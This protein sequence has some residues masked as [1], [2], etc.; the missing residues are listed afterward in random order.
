MQNKPHFLHQFGA[1]S[2]WT[3]HD[4]TIKAHEMFTLDFVTTKPNVFVITNSNNEAIKVGINNIPTDNSYEFK[5]E[6][7]STET[8]GRPVGTTK[9]YLLNTGGTEIN[10]IVFAID[11]EFDPEILKNTNVN[12]SVE[13]GLTVKPEMY[14]NDVNPGLV[15][16]MESSALAELLTE[17]NRLLTEILNKD[18][19]TIG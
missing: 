1:S 11:T 10:I 5:V 19:I 9:L 18:F 17:N 13:G 16:K 15:F 6:A 12:L 7:N 3:K 2:N 14:I 8:L 4:V